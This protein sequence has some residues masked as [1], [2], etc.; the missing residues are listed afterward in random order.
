MTIVHRLRLDKN[1][2]RVDLAR[3]LSI[4][5][6][7]IGI[8]VDRLLRQGYL[9]ESKPEEH[10]TGR[11][12]TALKLDPEAGHFIGVDLDA[13]Q[14]LARSFDFA[15]QPMC[16]C[17][18]KL[19]SSD[20]AENVIK[21]VQ[22]I[23]LKVQDRTRPLLGIGVAVPG[24]VDA[25]R[26]MALHYR[27]IR[28]WREIPLRKLLQQRFKAPVHLENNIRAMAI[29]ERCFGH[30]RNVDDFVCI[31]IRSG[32]GLGIFLS[33]Q[34][35][36]GAQQLAGEIGSWPQSSD[37][38]T[39]EDAASLRAILLRLTSAIRNG[40][41]SSIKA[42]R[43]TVTFP[44]LA[45][46]IKQ[47]DALA[48]GVLKRAAVAVASALVPITLLL[49]PSKIIIAGP[50]AEM[51]EHFAEPLI[52]ATKNHLPSYHIKLSE[53]VLSQLGDYVGALGAAALAV[54]QWQLE[55]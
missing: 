50:L 3:Q 37:G 40:A 8:H 36:R 5:P 19:R 48:L 1:L 14:I 11:P 27:Y 35:Y 49:N 38:T 28:G 41:P 44:S 33:G 9:R 43:G 39:L 31:G 47:K 26:G 4:A 55:S 21:K 51:G 53:I 52:T 42:T 20:S 24:A 7:T 17:T 30:G 25:D 29:A 46:A 22:E 18:M 23:L 12:P 6:S 32:I 34:L 54:N 15:Q 45:Q 13:R 2:S 10:A 16:D